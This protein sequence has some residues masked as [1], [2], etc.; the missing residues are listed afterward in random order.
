MSGHVSGCV[1]CHVCVCF[2]VF[3]APE[4]MSVARMRACFLSPEKY[5]L[6]DHGWVWFAYCEAQ[7]LTD[8]D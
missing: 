2:H 7:S 8:V 3:F 4:S 6:R 1:I 5:T